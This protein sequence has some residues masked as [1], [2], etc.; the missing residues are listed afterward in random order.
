[1]KRCLSR[2]NIN[3]RPEHQEKVTML[4]EIDEKKMAQEEEIASAKSLLQSIWWTWGTE[5]L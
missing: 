4:I 3:I 1:M 2:W 5:T